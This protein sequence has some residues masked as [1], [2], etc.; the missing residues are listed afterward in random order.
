EKTIQRVERLQDQIEALEDRKVD[1]AADRT[2]GLEELTRNGEQRQ[3]KTVQLSAIDDEK[4]IVEQNVSSASLSVAD[5]ANR[6][7]EE[8][9][10]IAT[11][12][13][14]QFETVGREARLR[15]EAG[16]RRDTATRISAQIERLETEEANARSQAN[17]LEQQ[18]TEAQNEYAGQKSGFVQ[19]KAQLQQ[20]EESYAQNKIDHAAAVKAAA[21][22]KAQE[23]SIRHRLQ[24][25]GELAVQRAYSTESVQQFFN[26]IRGSDWAPLGI[27]ADFVEVEPDYEALVEDFLRWKLQ[28]VVV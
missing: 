20:A 1:L 4:Q 3:E 13:Q 18:L 8:E 6:R 10:G 28:Y 11:L 16:S 23:E 24:T 26:A 27:L 17:V 15:N 12:R 14:R 9:R 21:E 22:A 25:I 19:L 2:R 7:N 5:C